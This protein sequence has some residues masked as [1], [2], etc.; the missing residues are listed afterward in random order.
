MY[1]ASIM[2]RNTERLRSSVHR[3][4]LQQFD[5]LIAGGA[6]W[7][8]WFRRHFSKLASVSHSNEN[9]WTGDFMI[10]EILSGW[11]WDDAAIQKQN[12]WVG[13]CDFVGLKLL[14]CAV[15][16]TPGEPQGGRS[17]SSSSAS[18]PACRSNRF[19]RS[20]SSFNK[21]IYWKVER[22]WET[23]SFWSKTTKN[24]QVTATVAY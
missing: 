17:G 18:V 16:M 24:A 3:S 20:S 15:S 10:L 9:R 23:F 1:S 2:Q 6:V 22:G 12:V 14:F 4:W 19:N 7:H 21:Y 13:I 5:S 8:F 11:V